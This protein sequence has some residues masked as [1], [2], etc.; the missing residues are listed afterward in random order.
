MVKKE[1]SRA[2]HDLTSEDPRNDAGGGPRRSVYFGTDRGQVSGCELHGITDVILKRVLGLRA[3]FRVDERILIQK[4]DAKSAFREV[5][6][7]LDNASR[8]AFR[9]G[10]F[11]FIDFRLQFRWRGSQG[12]WRYYGERDPGGG[13]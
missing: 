6:V 13:C 12:W 7:D 9:L 2:I 4:M 10:Q 8:L 5:G 11:L 1:H 3:K